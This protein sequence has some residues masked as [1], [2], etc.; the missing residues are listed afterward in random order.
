MEAAALLTVARVLGV[1]AASVFCISDV[2]HRGQWQ[3]YLHSAGVNQA[4][5][6][7]FEAVDACLT[8][9]PAAIPGRTGTP[10]TAPPGMN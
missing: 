2:L 4:L 3:P 8:T 1:Q 9:P 5:R 6:K 7:A 10:G